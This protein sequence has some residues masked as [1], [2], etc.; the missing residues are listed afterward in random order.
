MYKKNTTSNIVGLSQKAYYFFLA[1][2]EE[3]FAHYHKRSMIESAIS[4]VKRK[5]GDAVKAKT[6]MAMRNEALGKLICHNLYCVVSAVYQ[7]GVAPKFVR[8]PMAS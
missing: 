2:K 5:F 3:Y 4:M 1:N 8:L 7:R 6:D